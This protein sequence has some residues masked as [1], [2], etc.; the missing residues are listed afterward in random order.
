MPKIKLVTNVS[1]YGLMNG[2]AKTRLRLVISTVVALATTYL[3]GLWAADFI[4]ERSSSVVL[5]LGLITVMMMMLIAAAYLLTV[6]VGDLFFPGPWREQVLLGESTQDKQISVA[7][8]S[9]EFMIVLILAVVGNAYALNRVA[10]DFLTRYHNEGFYQVR[11]R[12]DDPEERL[13]ALE[14]IVDPMNYELWELEGIQQTVLDA[15]DDSD[16]EVRERAYWTAGHIELE[17]AQGDLL[18]VLDSEAEADEKAT[19][20][21]ALGKMGR[22]DVVYEPLEELALESEK[23]DAKV[24]ALKGLGLLEDDRVIEDI[25]PLLDH[26]NQEVMLHAYWALREIGSEEAR[27]YI[28]DKIDSDLEGIERCAAYDALKHTA[29]DD[30][31]TWAR[32]QFQRIED[33]EDACEHKIW[34]DLDDEQYYIVYGDSYPV[35]LIKIVANTAAYEYEDWFQQLVN[36]TSRPWRTREVADQVLRQI[37]EAEE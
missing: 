24:G 2:L 33:D 25:A 19:A 34:T 37:D 29:T 4:F 5:N 17:D 28:R 18:A 3:V 15:F 11:L 35:K 1:E 6:L 31:M 21:I 22:P 32:R 23:T 14:D 26:D 12:A 30:D 36:D 20:A 7:D 13:A 8:H 9:A 27:P 16:Q 10:D